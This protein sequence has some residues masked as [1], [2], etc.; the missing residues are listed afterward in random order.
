MADKEGGS[1]PSLV[2][3]GTVSGATPRTDSSFR[4]QL[5]NKAECVPKASVSKCHYC[6]RKFGL[7]VRK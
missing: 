6:E 3:K 7:T 4:L 1:S 2:R 5:M